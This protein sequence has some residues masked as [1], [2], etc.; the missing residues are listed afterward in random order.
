MPT[1]ADDLLNFIFV[2]AYLAACTMITKGDRAMKNL[3]I[4]MKE[5][6]EHPQ[7]N[8]AGMVLCH[9]GVVRETSRDGR[10]VRGLAVK[11]DRQRLLQ[12]VDKQKKHQGIVD[13]L[14]EIN[15]GTDLGVGDDVMFLVV[16]G[17]V[18]ETVITVLTDTLNEI[19]ETVTSKTEFFVE[20]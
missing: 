5:I 11:V 3:S 2:E 13:I 7:Y 12:I 19:K 9:N 15:E 16:A 8:K 6:K 1:D 20:E 14:V 18:R 10:K 17:D 4:L